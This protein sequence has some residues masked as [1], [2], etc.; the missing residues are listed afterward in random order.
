LDAAPSQTR[1]EPAFNPKLSN[2]SEILSLMVD[3]FV[4]RAATATLVVAGTGRR[5]S[6]FNTAWSNRP[7]LAVS[8]RPALHEHI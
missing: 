1:F 2:A 7:I 3:G 5:T 4:K 6:I 8:R